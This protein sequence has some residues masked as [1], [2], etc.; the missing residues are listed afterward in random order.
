[1][2]SLTS[3]FEPAAK[4]YLEIAGKLEQQKE[5]FGLRDFYSFI[6]MLVYFSKK[7]G[8]LGISQQAL[9]Y[10]VLRNFSGFDKFNLD[11]LDIFNRLVAPLI[12]LERDANLPD[13]CCSAI[14]ISQSFKDIPVYSCHFSLSY[15]YNGIPRCFGLSSLYR[16]DQER[17]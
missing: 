1:M 17:D 16:C 8:Y 7:S 2:D 5:F 6:K 12:A 13:D 9:R 15:L 11:S 3:L 10:S 4:A 14:G